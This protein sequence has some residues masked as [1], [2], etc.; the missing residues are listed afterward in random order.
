MRSGCLIIALLILCAAWLGPL[1]ALAREAF[2]AHMTLHMAVVAVAAPL[3]AIAVGAGAL[4][5]C[6]RRCRA[7]RTR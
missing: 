7:Y 5:P 4:P 2:F 1:P 3:L 6:G